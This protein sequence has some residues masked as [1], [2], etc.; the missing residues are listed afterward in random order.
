MHRQN[1]VLL[2]DDDLMLQKLVARQLEREGFAVSAVGGGA[3]ALAEAQTGDYDVIL[4]DVNLKDASGLEVLK[5]VRQLEDAPEVV[6]LTSDATL[7]TGLEAMRRGAYHYLTK[8]AHRDEL[9]AVLE[10]AAE[11]HRLVRQNSNLKA[12]A[13]AQ[14]TRRPNAVIY[15]SA[16]IAKLVQQAEAAARLNATLLITGESGTGKDVLARH[17]HAHSPRAGEPLVAI[18]CGALPETLFESEFFGH[19]RGSF[20]G[21]AN[22]KRGL[23]ETADGGTLFL[24]EIGDMPLTMQVKLLHFLEH[25]TF[26][27]IGSTREHETDVRLIAATNRNLLA[28]VEKERFRADLFY[29]L[30]VISLHVP[31]LRERPED[32]APLAEHFLNGYRQRFDRPALEFSPAALHALENYRWPGNVRELRNCIERAVALSTGDRLAPEDLFLPAVAQKAPAAPASPEK[33]VTLDAMERQY[34]LRVLEAM[35]R[36]RER[37]ATALGITTRTLYRKLQEYASDMT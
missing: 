24:D 22:L 9:A 19:E 13:A 25:G 2:V 34:I 7:Q 18:N 15:R 4:L 16:V 29:R 3:E 32:I 14:L 36:N 27:R 10:K 28:D 35:G 20:T 5:K 23:I 12:V 11:K 8:P 33:F 26:R 30:N 1:R 6:M 21:A 17:A 31:P 37:T